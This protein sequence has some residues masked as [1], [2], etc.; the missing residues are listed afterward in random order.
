MRGRRTKKKRKGQEMSHE[1][2]LIRWDKNGSGRGLLGDGCDHGDDR[3]S[4]LIYIYRLV[5]RGTGTG[6]H[7]PRLPFPCAWGG[8]A[9]AAVPSFITLQRTDYILYIYVG[10]LQ[11]RCS[12]G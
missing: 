10:L 11:A 5:S 12:G 1:W 7:R 3:A 8:R 2:D 9:R 4:R 6:H